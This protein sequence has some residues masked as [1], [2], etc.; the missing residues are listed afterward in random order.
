MSCLGSAVVWDSDT[1]CCCASEWDIEEVLSDNSGVRDGSRLLE[2]GGIRLRNF[3]L[4]KDGK[5]ILLGDGQASVDGSRSHS[6]DDGFAG[7]GA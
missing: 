6:F 4:G 3:Q 1:C 5:D 7:L 2:L